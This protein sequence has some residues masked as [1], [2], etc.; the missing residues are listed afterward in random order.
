MTGKDIRMITPIKNMARKI[1]TEERRKSLALR[2]LGGKFFIG[3]KNAGSRYSTTVEELVR[4]S[5]PDRP[6]Q[7][8]LAL[9]PHV[10]PEYLSSDWF[11]AET[12][13]PLYSLLARALQPKSIVEIGSL[14]G[15]SLISML[16]GASSVKDTV[17]VDNELYLPNSNQMCYE[18]IRFFYRTFHP[19]VAIPDLKFHHQTW[20]LLR[21]IH[22]GSFDLIHIDGAH[23]YEGKLRDLIVCSNLRPKYII[24][25]D[26]ANTANHEAIHYWAKNMKR[27]YAVIDTFE[28]GLA[29]F[30][31]TRDQKGFSLLKKHR[32]P[33]NE[34]VRCDA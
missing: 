22:A 4:L 2:L 11:W 7:N 21:Y 24:L 26:Y 32:I 31:F 3:K 5:P 15:F 8:I 9:L 34:T 33:V 20:D 6:V 25:D 1:L 19:H 23:T 10:Q 29:F 12:Y 28:R 14:Q 13:Y 30:D 16:N 18:N 17:W 27:D